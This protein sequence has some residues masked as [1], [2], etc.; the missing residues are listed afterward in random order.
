VPSVR[1]SGG[2]PRTLQIRPN[3]NALLVFIG[4]GHVT[5][6]MRAVEKRCHSSN[7]L[8]EG[9]RI[10]GPMS[11][12]TKTRAFQFSTEFPGLCARRGREQSEDLQ[13]SEPIDKTENVRKAR[14][15]AAEDLWEPADAI[16]KKEP[17]DSRDVARLTLGWTAP[18]AARSAPRLATA[19]NWRRDVAKKAAVS[20]NAPGSRDTC[21]ARG[22]PCRRS[23]V[24]APSATI[25][26]GQSGAKGS[27]VRTRSR[28]KNTLR[29]RI[30]SSLS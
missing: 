7:C 12:G 22:P 26:V 29:Q 30:T 8:L 10:I 4:L 23:A 15:L 27:G 16:R 1:V 6:W 24:A 17:A 20:G 18:F 3:P 13:P 11:A 25:P 5:Q 28:S 19:R 2:A 21:D 9:P 14:P